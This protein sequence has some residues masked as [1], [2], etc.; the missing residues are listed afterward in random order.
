[1]NKS[2]RNATAKAKGLRRARR[3]KKT[4]KLKNTEKKNDNFRGISEGACVDFKD[5]SNKYMDG[6]NNSSNRK[7]IM[8]AL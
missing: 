4:D 5:K 2:Q 6:L 8:R 7:R 3:K 1:M